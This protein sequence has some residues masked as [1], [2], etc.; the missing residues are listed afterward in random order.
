MEDSRW[1]GTYPAP[2]CVPYS[3]APRTLWWLCR[4]T[5]GTGC[6]DR[7]HTTDC[8]TMKQLL[9]PIG[10]LL[11]LLSV[12]IGEVCD[13]HLR[14]LCSCLG[15]QIIDLATAQV[16]QVQPGRPPQLCQ[17]STTDT[18]GLDPLGSERQKIPQSIAL[19]LGALCHVSTMCV[20]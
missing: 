15:Q 20:N 4:H 11:V 3:E 5:S 9:L 10:S 18:Q 19:A 12:V 7:W 16:D 2:P 17:L 6:R 14:Q 8:C 1:S 13:D